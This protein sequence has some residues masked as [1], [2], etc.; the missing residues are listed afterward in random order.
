MTRIVIF[1]YAVQYYAMHMW[2]VI[3]QPFEISE[4]FI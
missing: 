1:K 2:F 3:S 4:N